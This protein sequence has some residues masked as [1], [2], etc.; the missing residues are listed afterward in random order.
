MA[1]GDTPLDDTED[2][3]DAVEPSPDDPPVDGRAA[4]AAG[5]AAGGLAAGD[6]SAGE[7][8]AGH[9]PPATVVA[10][11]VD[12]KGSGGRSSRG[13]TRL[14]AVVAG[15]VL[16]GAAAVV[17]AVWA[18]TAILDDDDHA[19]YYADYA[20]SLPSDD[21]WHEEF[22]SDP[23]D[24]DRG[25][26][27]EWRSGER[28]ERGDR[29]HRERDLREQDERKGQER[30]DRREREGRERAER[31]REAQ[32]GRDEWPDSD[33]SSPRG[34]CRTILNF[35][36][37]D[38]A[39]AVLVCRAPGA[40]WPGFEPRDDGEHF[41]G[42]GFGFGMLP[43]DAFPFLPDFDRRGERWPFKDG[44][45]FR[46]WRPFLDERFF[47]DDGY[48]EGDDAYGDDGY[49]EGDDAYGEGLPFDVEEFLESLGAG[50]P[51]LDDGYFEGDG[52]FEGDDAYPVE[53]PFDV[54]EFLESL[55]DGVPFLDEPWR[56]EEG[57][58]YEDEPP[59][60]F[61]GDGR[62]N[63]FCLRMGDAET[64]R[65]LD[66]MSAV[67]REQLEQMMGMLD[68]LGLEGLLD[69]L[70]ELLDGLELEFG[71]SQIYPSGATGA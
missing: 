56:F 59:E 10:Q 46:G 25:E 51:F 47:E 23:R 4:D 7:A 39:V 13:T 67:E 11:D 54:E 2:A 62:S 45:A 26:L 17:G 61:R 20:A 16:A 42:E 5:E 31:D 22:G 32:S 55:G 37:G 64:C 58:A 3:E 35:G 53:L 24:R 52:F 66:E 43:R 36:T 50:V 1:D 40:G 15:A 14:A 38:D 21:A 70:E 12:V 19:P 69:G 29:D 30:R 34:R 65:G 41:G 44:G 71:E 28:L 63:G 9:A 57:D 18:V 6:V 33:W 60:R 68:A 49:F 48:F 8:T 27:K